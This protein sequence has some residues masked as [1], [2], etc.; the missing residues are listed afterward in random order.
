MR[1]DLI[2]R[3]PFWMRRGKWMGTGRAV[4]NHSSWAS[5]SDLGRGNG[6]KWVPLGCVLEVEEIAPVI[7]CTGEGTPYCPE[8]QGERQGSGQ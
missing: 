6:Q 7:G 5:G 4:G 3:K 1:S 8:D 2:F